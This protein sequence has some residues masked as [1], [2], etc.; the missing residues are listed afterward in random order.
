MTNAIVH[1]S[2]AV[3][4]GVND[5]SANTVIG[6]DRPNRTAAPAAAAIP[7]CSRVSRM[8]AKRTPPPGSKP[9]AS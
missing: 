6:N 2:A 7:N 1:D 9:D 8:T 3:P 5:R 4:S